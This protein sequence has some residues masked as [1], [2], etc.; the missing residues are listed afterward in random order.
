MS[1]KYLQ[2]CEES[3]QCEESVSTVINHNSIVEL[4]AVNKMISNIV[5][6]FLG[7]ETS[8]AQLT[9]LDQK[10]NGVKSGKKEEE[11]SDMKI[12]N[13]L[14]DMRGKTCSGKQFKEMMKN[15]NLQPMQLVLNANDSPKMPQEENIHVELII[16]PPK[17]LIAKQLQKE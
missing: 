9:L 15:L 11:T 4:I 3:V 6:D 13:N 17:D 8:K 14:N 12:S 7:D 2:T 1:K 16:L 10:F 5:K